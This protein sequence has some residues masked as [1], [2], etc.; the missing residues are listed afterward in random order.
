MLQICSSNDRVLLR[1]TPRQW[2]DG[3]KL[4]FMH[5]CVWLVY[6]CLLFVLGFVGGGGYYVVVFLGGGGGYS[7]RRT[8]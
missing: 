5:V 4:I 6:G 2:T 7:A 3:E 1:M 8:S